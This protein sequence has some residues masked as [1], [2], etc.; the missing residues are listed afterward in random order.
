MTCEEIRGLLSPY[1]DAELD[2]V[3][4]LEIEQHL[5]ECPH[6]AAAVEQTRSLR[7]MLGDPALYHPPPADLSG[8][9]RASLGLAD[10]ARG[11]LASWPWGWLSAVAG[12]A[13][14]VALVF[15]AAQQGRP[16]PSGDELLARQVVA[17]HVRSLMLPSHMLDVKSSDQHTVKPW[18]N[19][20]V[21]VVPEVKDLATQGF[22]LSGG[23]L[24]YLEDRPAA[25]LVYGRAQHVINVFIW[26]TTEKDRPPELL[27]RQG[28]HLIRW[29]EN[30]R[31]FWVI[32]DL[33]AKELQQF[34]ELL[35]Q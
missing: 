17:A 33:N 22:P 18:F 9:I 26:K 34:S 29:T 1:A 6:C 24:E 16:A 12:T 25:A 3:R 23:R 21:D 19:G 30:E 11:R 15:W 31:M 7:R 8:R 27:Q 5:Q 4:E 28:Y 2:L 20:K 10:R 13:A 32:S 14:L 35:R